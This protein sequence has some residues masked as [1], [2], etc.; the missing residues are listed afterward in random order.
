MGG[1]QRS[2]MR[3]DGERPETKKGGFAGYSTLQTR[4]EGVKAYAL[5]VY[6]A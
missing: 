6:A 5:T 4:P 3:A 2:N 1:H